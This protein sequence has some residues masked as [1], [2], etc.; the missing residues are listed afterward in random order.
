MRYHCARCRE[1]IAEDATRPLGFLA[2]P[3]SAV[4]GGV[5]EQYRPNHHI[6][7][8]DRVVDATDA[9]P[10]WRTLVQGEQMDGGTV[11]EIIGGGGGSSGDT[12]GSAG[13]AV[14]ATTSVDAAAASALHDAA[15]GR[16]RKDVLPLSPTRPP[17]PGVYHFTE[18]DPIA[19]HVTSV[20]PEKVAER[21]ARKYLPSPG[22][23]VA[24]TR[25][26]RDVVIV[27]GG[28]NA[29]TAAAYLAKAGLDVLVLERR[30]VV[31]G[32]AV[33][34]ELTPG[35]KFS[36]ASYLA[37]LL[38]PS[39]IDELRLHDYGFKYL[40][41]DPSSFTPTPLDGV[42]GGKA[43]MLGG[44]E[45]RT[46]ASVAQFSVRDA[47]ALPRYEE[48]MGR[49]RD[50]VQ[51]IIDGPPPSPG[52]SVKDWRRVLRHALSLGGAAWQHRDVLVPFYE[53][54]TGAAA[55]VRARVCTRACDLRARLPRT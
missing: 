22:A 11:G 52:V 34:E 40:P 46:W 54:F 39:V 24:P 23:F 55:R 49:V 20:A 43:L 42:H 41:R 15:T 27:G 26:T 45:A 38:R 19:N 31:G 12:S 9:L 33:T 3:L 44:D 29:L 47:D 32:A 4:R 13:G 36:R 51:P 37:G 16:F 50:L 2:L 18:T 53:L 28:H 35:F 7:Y 17:Y 6:F 21:V 5:P 14:P 48:F 30:H 1:Y 10:K 8:A 25:T